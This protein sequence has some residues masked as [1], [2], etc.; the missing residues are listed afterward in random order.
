MYIMEMSRDRTA[1]SVSRDQILRHE[2]NGYREIFI[3][4]VQLTTSRIDNLTRLILILATCVTIHRVQ[5]RTSQLNTDYDTTSIIFRS[6]H[7]I[8]SINFLM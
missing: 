8:G 5:H 7:I 3:F 6:D 4:P 1:E 2:R